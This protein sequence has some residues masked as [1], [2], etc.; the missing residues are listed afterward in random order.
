MLHVLCV[1][2]RS[3]DHSTLH[4]SGGEADRAL[5]S[6]P[7]QPIRNQPTNQLCA[8]NDEPK[9]K[10]KGASGN[11]VRCVYSV[12]SKTE[13]ELRAIVEVSNDDDAIPFQTAEAI[14]QTSTLTLAAK[15]QR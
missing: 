3:T 5:V 14:N 12:T 2:A 7:L 1:A 6:A 8:T 4:A 9:P 13:E 10:V 11:G 15:L